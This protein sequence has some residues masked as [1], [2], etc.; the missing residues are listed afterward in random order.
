MK[1]LILFL[2]ILS[3]G[4]IACVS[5]VIPEQ[6][7]NIISSNNS[8]KPE[9]ININSKIKN[10]SNFPDFENFNYPQFCV[11]KD[12][13]SFLL[14]DGKFKDKNSEFLFA[15]VK[16]A[17]VTGDHNDEAIV[18]LDM[19]SGGSSMP[20]CVYIFQTK[21]QKNKK[22]ELIWEFLTGDRAYGGLRNIYGENGDLIVENYFAEDKDAAC[23]PTYF[24]KKRFKWTGNKF[25][26]ESEEKLVNTSQR[27]EPFI[28]SAVPQG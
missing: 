19:I 2:I 27:Y 9:Q 11:E 15:G 12:N 20:R 10:E 1:H 16:Y 5:K 28:F 6:D 7:A 26:K 3:S 4:V 18:I 25:K 13:T 24:I 17:D 21:E 8:Q 23:C 14:K 22:I